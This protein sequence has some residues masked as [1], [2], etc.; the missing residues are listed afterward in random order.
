MDLLTATSPEI[1]RAETDLAV[2]PVG[3][4]EQHGP[5]APIG[6]D[7][8]TAETVAQAGIERFE[9]TAL[10]APTIP[11]G[12][13]AEHRHFPGTMWVTPDTFRSYL[14]EC[15][16]SLSDQGFDRVVLVNGHGGNV[17]ALAELTGEI[18]RFDD[19]YA[20]AFTWFE[21]LEAYPGSMGHGG[22]IETSVL[23]HLDGSLVREDTIDAA[24]EAGADRWGEWIG[25]VNLTH[26]A[27]EF[28]ENGVVGDPRT[29]TASAGK[30]YL[31]EAAEALADVLSAV[32][33]RKIGE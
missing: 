2:I 4:T 17:D 28:S 32:G 7:V 24:A 8:V 14:R 1:E 29:A 31:E 9:G 10:R 3:S 6:T 5:H 30:G 19:A 15:I 20:V 26:D 18:S 33:S 27:A 21:P 23:L 25:S 13:A 16:S 22:H 11:V 12:V